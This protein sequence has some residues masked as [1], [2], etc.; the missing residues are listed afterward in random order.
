MAVLSTDSPRTFR[1][2]ALGAHPTLNSLSISV[3]PDSHHHRGPQ[4]L[5]NFIGGVGS[6]S[7]SDLRS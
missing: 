3:A 5:L 6:S 2:T 7:V 4:G 1:R